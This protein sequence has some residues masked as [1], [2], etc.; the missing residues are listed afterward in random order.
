[1]K[2]MLIMLLS[3][4]LS[5]C[6]VSIGWLVCQDYDLKALMICSLLA[7]LPMPSWMRI[8]HMYFGR[9]KNEINY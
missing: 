4:I 9:N 6:L 8:L 1:M 7:L 3:F 2:N 5:L